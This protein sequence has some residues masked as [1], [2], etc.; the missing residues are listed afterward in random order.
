MGTYQLRYFSGME[1]PINVVLTNS[2][3]SVTITWAAVTGAVS[4]QIEASSDPYAGFEVIGTT[5]STSWTGTSTLD[6]GFYR[7]R[8]TDIPVP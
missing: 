5:S 1:A 4:Y 3:S 6:R 8:A 7:I 2:G